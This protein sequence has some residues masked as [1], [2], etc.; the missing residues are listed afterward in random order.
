MI[1]YRIELVCSKIPPKHDASTPYWLLAIDAKAAKVQA[2]AHWVYPRDYQRHG[3]CCRVQ[4]HE[5]VT[6][7]H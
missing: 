1:L 2:Q 5:E 4:V 3:K 6:D 7:G